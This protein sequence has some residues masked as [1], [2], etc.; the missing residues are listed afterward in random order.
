MCERTLSATELFVLCVNSV[1]TDKG[2]GF[3]LTF[4][5]VVF[6]VFLSLCMCVCV[7]VCAGR[8]RGC[9]VVKE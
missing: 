5:F 3:K 8:G 9:L 1:Q 6:P 2:M 7:C 4:A